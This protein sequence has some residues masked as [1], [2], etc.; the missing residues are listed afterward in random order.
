MAIDWPWSRQRGVLCPDGSTHFV[1]K[2]VDHVF[3]YYFPQAKLSAAAALDGLKKVKG[4][5]EVKYESRI[6]DILFRIDQKNGSVQYHLRAAYVVY[7]AAP[8]K[9][10]DYLQ[11]A[12]DATR[13]G[14]QELRGADMAIRALVTL[15]SIPGG[16]GV[17][18]PAV[19]ARI[20]EH[21]GQV[22]K[23]L[24]HKTPAELLI[25]QMKNVAVNTKEWRRP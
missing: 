2:N 16:V 9:K 23:A 11:A 7:S 19:S 18:D 1:F 4:K 14:E 22:V 6:E 5:V 8:C 24:N 21:L 17:S 20:S 15:L 12:I 3:P 25:E 13:Q 10:L